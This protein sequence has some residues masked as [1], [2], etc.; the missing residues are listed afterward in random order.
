MML[1]KMDKRDRHFMLKPMY[2][3]VIGVYNRA[4]CSLCGTN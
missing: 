4:D 2:V 3:Y 1:L